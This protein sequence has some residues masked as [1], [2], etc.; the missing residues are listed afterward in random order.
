MSSILDALNK[1]D[2]EKANARRLFERSDV[3][4]VAA[5][6][7]LVGRSLLRDRVTLRV[8]PGMLLVY[9]LAVVMGVSALAALVAIALLRPDRDRPTGADSA[10]A[11]A[12]QQRAADFDDA[13]AASAPPER[14]AGPVL[15]RLPEPEPAPAPQQVQ[16]GPSMPM[17]R[18]ADA[19]T[20][21]EPG[22]SV[23]TS[24]A[25]IAP[26]PVRSLESVADPPP[27]AAAP[28]PAVQSAPAST[29]IED[30]SN[31]RVARRVESVD[32]PRDR[33]LP[34]ASAPA[35]REPVP[36]DLHNLPVLTPSDIGQFG[37]LQLKV[38]MT[39]PASPTNVRGS[40]V[41]TVRE[42]A[43]VAVA[44]KPT[45]LYEGQRIRTTLLRLLKV[46]SDGVAIEDLKTGQRYWLPF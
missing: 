42:D 44:I 27:P 5:T 14:S 2:Q 40:A 3:D 20:P 1:L 43:A 23:S 35:P 37:L 28:P 36:E 16:A 22:K 17:T 25:T 32:T 41:M 10:L 6:H 46:E 19:A 39:T 38:N 13:A 15:V 26:K 12:P 18:P 31:Q 45:T 21:H 34:A 9:A 33:P 11:S 4:P 30:A 24:P 8:S 7:D 29:S